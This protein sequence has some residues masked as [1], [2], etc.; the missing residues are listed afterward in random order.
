M[1]T[2]SNPSLSNKLTKTDF[3][4]QMENGTVIIK[5]AELDHTGYY[6]CEAE[7]GIG[8]PLTKTV[9]IKVRGNNLYIYI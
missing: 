7:N 5:S 3:V 4:Q 2:G 9:I 1:F 8:M 6:T